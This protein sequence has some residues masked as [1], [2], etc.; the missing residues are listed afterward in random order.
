MTAPTL[1]DVFLEVFQEDCGWPEA[2]I[3]L[4]KT[5]TDEELEDLAE[6]VLKNRPQSVGNRKMR[7]HLFYKDLTEAK[8]DIRTDSPN[9]EGYNSNTERTLA[10]LCDKDY[11]LTLINHTWST[12][13]IAPLIVKYRLECGV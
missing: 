9:R 1:Q 3:P 12:S 13:T 2:H 7:E 11:V 5:W 10:L 6:Y 8:E 4:T